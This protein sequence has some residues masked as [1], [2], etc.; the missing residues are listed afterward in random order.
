M[1]SNF[2]YL[3][4][5]LLE[6]FAKENIQLVSYAWSLCV[7]RFFICIMAALPSRWMKAEFFKKQ[8]GAF[9]ELSTSCTISLKLPRQLTF[10][11]SLK[12]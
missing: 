12:I 7:Y 3:D 6:D 11:T 9:S 2:Q 8:S 10:K 1:L 5:K 4:T